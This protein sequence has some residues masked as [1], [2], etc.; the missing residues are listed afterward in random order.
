MALPWTKTDHLRQGQRI[1][2]FAVT[3][4]KAFIARWRHACAPTLLRV[5]E[6]NTNFG[7]EFRVRIEFSGRNDDHDLEEDLQ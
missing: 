6:S 5:A 7:L 2:I 4:K 1:A 3:T